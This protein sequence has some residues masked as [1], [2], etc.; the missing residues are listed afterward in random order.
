MSSN[1]TISIRVSHHNYHI[2]KIILR[3]SLYGKVFNELCVRKSVKQTSFR[4]Q[5]CSNSENFQKSHKEK[6]GLR[7]ILL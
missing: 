5:I 3:L 1:S 2:A 7:V 6:L 4:G